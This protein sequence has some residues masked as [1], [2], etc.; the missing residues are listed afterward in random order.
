MTTG[1]DTQVLSS[2]VLWELS[3][4]AASDWGPYLKQLPKEY[5]SFLSWQQDDIAALQVHT[6]SC[7]AMYPAY[8]FGQKLT[9]HAILLCRF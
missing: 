9:L 1:S 6:P 7:D 2:L 3:K 5:S 8:H 4:G